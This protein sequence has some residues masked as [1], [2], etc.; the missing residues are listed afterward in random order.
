MSHQAIINRAM[1]ELFY[2]NERIMCGDICSNKTALPRCR[3]MCDG[4]AEELSWAGCAG[5]RLEPYMAAG[6]W[7][8]LSYSYSPPGAEEVSSS[9]VP[10]RLP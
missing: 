3:K 5:I 6:G 8:G 9:N 4:W 10:R 2:I 7:V 1:K